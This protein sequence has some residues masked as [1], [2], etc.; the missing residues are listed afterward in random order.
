MTRNN[1]AVDGAAMLHEIL[2]VLRDSGRPLDQTVAIIEKSSERS[3]LECG[4]PVRR[5]AYERRF[6]MARDIIAQDAPD[7]DSAINRDLRDLADANDLDEWNL[8]LGRLV[9]ALANR[10]ASPTECVDRKAFDDAV[11]WLVFAIAGGFVP[12]GKRRSSPLLLNED[13]DAIKE[14]GVGSIAGAT[15]V[16][17]RRDGADTA[18]LTRQQRDHYRKRAIAAASH[19]SIPLKDGR[20]AGA[21]R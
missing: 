4:P 17:A 21:N 20:H 15:R 2:K 16:L 14:S 5:A 13:A 9:G 3:R 1:L 7:L 11:S 12:V 6:Q 19:A 18:E 10:C 8:T